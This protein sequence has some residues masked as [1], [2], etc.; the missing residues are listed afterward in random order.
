M[1]NYFKYLANLPRSV[2]GI[3]LLGID[4]VILVFS[5][6]LAIAVRFDIVIIENNYR[7]FSEGAW[8]LIGMQILALLISGL[9]RSVLRYAG[10]E[11]LVLLLRSVLLGAGMFA[12]IDLMLEEYWMA[13]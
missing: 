2:K 8:V 9:Y 1:S 3:L 5:L 6:L 12:L 11:L 10:T 7:E 13:R 4:V